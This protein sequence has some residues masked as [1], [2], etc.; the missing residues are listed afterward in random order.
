MQNFIEKFRYEIAEQ[1][2]FPP[3]NIYA[4][5]KIERFSTNGKPTNKDGW[6]VLYAG[7]ISAG[8]FGDW[9]KGVTHTW[10]S[11]RKDQMSQSEWI[12]HRRQMIEARQLRDLIIKENHLRSASRAREIWDAAVFASLNHPY[13]IKKRISPFLA[14]Q[15]RNT[16]ILPI[17]D[18]N[19]CLWSLQFIEPDGSK[20]LLSGGAKKEH[21]ILV[22]GTI[23]P[24]SLLLIC[25]GFAT[26][27]TLAEA[28]P[29]A[30]VISAIDAGNL[31]PVAIKARS[32]FPNTEIV[33]CADDDRQ[34]TG[35]PGISKGREAALAARALFTSPQWPEGAPITLSDF[36]DLA[37]WLLENKGG[38]HE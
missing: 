22:S 18:F 27:A 12:N 5:A 33:I 7:A 8:A 10:C 4:T 24:S 38:Q 16:L 26:G 13:L 19:G 9:R 23:L 30:C 28:Y 20:K 37:R 2:I 35:N 14:R 1:G 34:T 11:K 32:H 36:N 29:D 21:L 17:V 31:K 25:E 3:A 15:K 6:Y